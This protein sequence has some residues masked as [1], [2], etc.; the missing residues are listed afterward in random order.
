MP[1][2]FSHWILGKRIINDS[3][4]DENYPEINQAAFLWGCQGPDIFFYHRLMPWQKNDSIREYGNILHKCNPTALFNS[5]SKVC[6]YCYGTNDFM[7]VYSYALGF[8]CHYCYDRRLHPLVYYNTA[9]LEKT[10]ERGRDY[11]YHS[12]IESNM[13]IIL[14]RSETSLLTSEI[15]MKE[16]LPQCPDLNKAVATVYR[17]LLMDMYSFRPSKKSAMTLTSDFINN[18]GLLDDAHSVK[19][20]IVCAAEK[21]LP[22]VREGSL[23]G[24][25]HAVSEDTGFDYANLLKNTWFNPD[26][27]REKSNM[28]LYEI[29]DAAQ[30][31]TMELIKIFSCAVNDRHSVSF[32]E[33]TQGI[34]FEGSK[35]I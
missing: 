29:T 30:S 20:H 12:D 14:L 17:L 15:S 5:L 7:A 16:C 23:S 26:D 21:I 8:C 19:K 28:N 3:Y 33:F 24:L 35:S 9:L 13:D 10:D 18:I 11:K 6:R 34:N 27:R 31:D 22:N 1:A 2:A 32:N 25:I 4:F